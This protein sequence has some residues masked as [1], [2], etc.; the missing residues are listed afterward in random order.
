[1]KSLLL[2]DDPD[3]VEVVDAGA[4]DGGDAFTAK[5][6]ADVMI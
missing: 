1:V 2:L 3:D 6:T 4:G 5:T